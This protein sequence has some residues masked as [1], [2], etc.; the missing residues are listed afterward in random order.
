[1]N[2]Q[3]F[4]STLAVWFRGRL[5]GKAAVFQD[6]QRRPHSVIVLPHGW[7][8][9]RVVLD[10]EP[11]RLGHWDLQ[12]GDDR[13]FTITKKELGELAKWLIAE[14]DAGREIHSRWSAAAWER[15][16]GKKGEPGTTYLP[17]GPTT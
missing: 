2:V 11:I 10:R 8:L 16:T 14:F 17:F 15:K 1:M 4:L 5:R 13:E 9:Y 3:L 7:D 6:S 12:L